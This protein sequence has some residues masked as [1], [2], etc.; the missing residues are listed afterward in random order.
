MSS[1][2]YKTTR[3]TIHNSTLPG[4]TSCRP[5]PSPLPLTSDSAQT[6]DPPSPPSDPPCPLGY[7]ATRQQRCSTPTLPVSPAAAS[8]FEPAPIALDDFADDAPIPPPP[9]RVHQGGA[10]ILQAQAACGFRAF[11]QKRLFSAALDSPSLG[12]DPGERGSL[13]HV[14][15]QRF[16]AEVKTQ[17]ALKLMTRDECGAQ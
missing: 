11:A 17:A 13:V 15:L 6:S 1:P 4:P 16:W 14:V 10:A 7:P 5:P 3:T 8:R 2:E 9:D 12:L